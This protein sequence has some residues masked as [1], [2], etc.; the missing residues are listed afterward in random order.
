[1]NSPFITFDQMISN[2]SRFIDD[3]NCN[4][5]NFEQQ[6]IKCNTI[7]NFELNLYL[8]IRIELRD[9]KPQSTFLNIHISDFDPNNIKFP[10]LKQSF[11]IVKSAILFYP[12]NHLDCNQ[13]GYYVNLQR[14]DKQWIEIS[15]QFYKIRTTFPKYLENVYI[16]FL[17]KINHI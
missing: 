11:Y 10:T 2:Q 3:F 17:E 15:D 7:Y 13:G 6:N 12:T 1:M 5:C 16:L 9:L 14:Y 4:K 8:I